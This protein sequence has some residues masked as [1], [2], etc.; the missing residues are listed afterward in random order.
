MT[1]IYD[2]FY[3]QKIVF[4]EN[5]VSI[6]IQKSE[7]KLELAV[8][9]TD[10][11]VNDQEK[12]NSQSFLDNILGI[13]LGERKIGYA[14][15]DMKKYV[16]SGVLDPVHENNSPIVGSVGVPSIRNL[17]KKVTLLR[18]NTAQFKI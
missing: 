10:Q 9:I 18:K 12:D 14:L 16:D 2:Q 17:M 4:H 13:D 5:K 6:K 3:Q 8:P 7:F 11:R 1:L 15:F